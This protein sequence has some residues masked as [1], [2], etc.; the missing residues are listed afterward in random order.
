MKTPEIMTAIRFKA[1]LYYRYTSRH[2]DT[3][4]SLLNPMLADPD[5]KAY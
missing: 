3:F 5:R 4:L 1:M 2:D